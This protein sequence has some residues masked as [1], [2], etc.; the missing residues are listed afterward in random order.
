M[1]YE[2]NG[3]YART[4]IVVSDLPSHIPVEIEMVV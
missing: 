2:E 1:L 3:K 4:S